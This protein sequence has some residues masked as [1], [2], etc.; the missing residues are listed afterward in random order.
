MS[1]NNSNRNGNRRQ[2]PEGQKRSK[3]RRKSNAKASRE[4]WGDPEKLPAEDR[5]VKISTEPAAVVASLGR[6]PLPGQET[7][8]DHYFKVVYERGVMIAGALASASDLVEEDE[9]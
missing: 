7:A 2:R 5:R 8:A 3:R 4:F 1:G 9:S 6:V